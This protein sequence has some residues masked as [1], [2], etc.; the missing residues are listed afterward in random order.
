MSRMN[1][2]KNE[3][4]QKDNQNKGNSG[5]GF[6]A[7]LTVLVVLCMCL[8]IVFGSLKGN[9]T[10]SGFDRGLAELTGITA[11]AQE[12]MTPDSKGGRV[13]DQAGLLSSSEVTDI[14]DQLTSIRKSMNFDVVV[15]T[16]EEADGKTAQEYADDFFDDGG[17]GTG[18]KKNGILFLIDMDNREIALSTSGDA[19]RI[20]T[21][22]V[23][24]SMLDDAYNGVSQGDYMASVQAFLDDAEYYGAKGIQDGQYNYDTETGKVSVYRSIR[25]YEFLIT[26]AVSAGVAASVCLGVKRQYNMEESKGQVANHN[27]AYRADS[28]MVYG[29]QT[30]NLVNKHVTSRIIPR[31]TGSSGSRSGGSSHSSSAGRSSTHHSSSGRTHGGGSRKF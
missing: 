10:G 26:F 21:D 11:Y 5:R 13:Y 20:F 25:W 30:D 14:E 7:R 2:I 8:V 24:E 15:V 29:T 31:N 3:K 19:I 16:T 12:T 1:W 22:R 23:I 4:K 27:L 17:F 6:M 18:L 9:I 28:H